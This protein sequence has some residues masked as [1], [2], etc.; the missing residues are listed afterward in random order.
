MI[1]SPG[2]LLI[3]LMVGIFLFMLFV[4]GI[5]QLTRYVNVL[6]QAIQAR[7]V[8]VATMNN[9]IEKGGKNNDVDQRQP[10]IQV[11]AGMCS[12]NKVL[13]LRAITL[14][15]QKGSYNQTWQ[16]VVWKYE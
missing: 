12:S 4:I 10:Y 2:F 13:S 5:M 16:Q 6:Q 15:Y 1:R 11:H 8:L 3:E 7:C 14:E 9:F